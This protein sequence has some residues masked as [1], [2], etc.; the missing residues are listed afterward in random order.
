MNNTYTVISYNNYEVKLMVFLMRDKKPY[1]I[2][3]EFIEKININS[4]TSDLEKDKLAAQVSDAFDRSI[5]VSKAR[6][7]NVYLVFDAH[8][9]FYDSKTFNFDFTDEHVVTMSD[10]QK[11]FKHSMTS[12]NVKSGFIPIHF[13]INK[14]FNQ[15]N[16]AIPNPIGSSVTKLGVTG[17]LVFSDSNTF[18]NVKDIIETYDIKV[19]DSIV[20]GY[21][22]NDVIN[23]DDNHGLMEISTDRINF[24]VNTDGENKQFSVEMGFRKIL[25]SVYEKL[26]ESHNYEDSEGAVRFLMEYFPIKEYD[27][28]FYVVGDIKLNDLIAVFNHVIIDYFNYIFEQLNKQ[29]INCTMFNVILHDYV[30]HDF[31]C[32]LN[33]NLSI[34]FVEY[35]NADYKNVDFANLKAYLAA[36]A[37]YEKNIQVYE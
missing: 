34:T 24:A 19:I 15:D 2:F 21:L 29:N 6:D 36:S 27:S 20:G 18:Y 10:V 8:N 25:E 11:V 13:Q 17:E 31:V 28:E 23:L 16:K 1:L 12:E 26:I 22:L 4:F 5:K 32:L 7:K 33:K 30:S 14:F 9:Y 35:K 37:F 3:E